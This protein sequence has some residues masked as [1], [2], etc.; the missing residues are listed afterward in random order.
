MLIIPHKRGLFFSLEG[1]AR[2]RLSSKLLRIIIVQL[3]ASYCPGASRCRVNYGRGRRS[4][5]RQDRGIF[6]RRWSPGCREKQKNKGRNSRLVE[7]SVKKK[8]WGGEPS[9]KFLHRRGSDLYAAY[10]PDRMQISCGLITRARL[11]H[12]VSD[13][14]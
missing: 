2:M 12:E 10:Q 11:L 5:G 14:R 8:K 13:R 6:N 9:F 3:N 7:A 4:Y 1:T